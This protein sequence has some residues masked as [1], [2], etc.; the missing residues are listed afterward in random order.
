MTLN[1]AAPPVQE[2]YDR[3]HAAYGP[4]SWW[5]ADSAFE[6][7]VGAILVQN[8]AWENVERAIDNLK[9]LSALDPHYLHA[10]PT[11]DLEQL[12]RP[13][14]V[15][16]VK[17]KRLQAVLAY[18]IERHGGDTAAL[19]RTPTE[20]LRRELLALH[21]VG[22]ETADSILLYA[23]EQPSF[24]IDAYTRRVLERHGW[25]DKSASYDQLKQSFETALPRDVQLFNE[26]HA[27]IVEVGKRHCRRTPKCEG[28]PLA[29]L[30]PGT[31]P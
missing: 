30:L 11:S 4:Q 5:P 29:E 16:R 12:I 24:V 2:I 3:L 25:A 17:A 6:V 21:G 10:L 19:A 26:Y 9:R 13:A 15:F 14:G 23:A 20:E 8:T 31:R 1:P 18:L 27:L 22:P 28:C 7:I